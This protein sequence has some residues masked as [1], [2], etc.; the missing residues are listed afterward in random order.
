MTSALSGFALG[1]PIDGRCCSQTL[2]RFHPNSALSYSRVVN[3]SKQ[4]VNHFQL[5]EPLDHPVWGEGGKN[6][7]IHEY[8]LYLSNYEIKQ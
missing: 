5:T 4:V 2:E 1:L 8:F 6:G 3:S 7:G